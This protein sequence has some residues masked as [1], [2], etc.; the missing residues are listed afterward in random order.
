V[1]IVRLLLLL[2]IAGVF[3]P[4]GRSEEKPS[5]TITSLDS[6]TLSGYVITSVSFG[7]TATSSHT[8]ALRA[9]M[10]LFY[11]HWRWVVR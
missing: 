2:A 11:F 8:L 6:T 4:W 9:Y 1:K 10:R 3:I 5:S 7:N